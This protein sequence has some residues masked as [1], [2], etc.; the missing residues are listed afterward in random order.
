MRYVIL[1]L[2]TL[3]GLC[4]FSQKDTLFLFNDCYVIGEEKYNKTIN[5]VKEGRW[6]EYDLKMKAVCQINIVHWTGIDSLGNDASGTYY[7]N[8]EYAPT[9]DFDSINCQKKS[10][11]S[12][13]LSVTTRVFNW[14]PPEKYYI[15]SKGT[16]KLGLKEG[17]WVSYYENEQIKKKIEF[18]NG[19]P[20]N[21]FVV[22]REDG[23]I[24]FSVSVLDD[25]NF[26]VC[27]FLQHQKTPKCSIYTIEE[28]HVLLK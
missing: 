8:D 3:L 17:V 7:V 13:A 23:T 27:R 4:S 1:F 18:K 15:A 9:S 12:N 19:R 6:L 24:M 20:I 11:D 2:L 10:K 16:Y 25:D 14:I 21:D 22:F 5:G 26:E 28:I